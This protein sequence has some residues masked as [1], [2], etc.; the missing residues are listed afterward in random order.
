M[1]HSIKVASIVL[2]CL[3]PHSCQI[4]NDGN[5]PALR[6]NSVIFYVDDLSYG[7]KGVYG[8]RAVSTPTIKAVRNSRTN[9]STS[10]G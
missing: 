8:A 6:P 5:T 4:N 9:P 10:S 7:E 1:K 2:V 3:F